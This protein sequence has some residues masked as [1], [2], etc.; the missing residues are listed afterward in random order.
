MKFP[1]VSVTPPVLSNGQYSIGG[2]LLGSG[3]TWAVQ[4]ADGL[5]L[6]KVRSQDT[7]RP[8][9][10]GEFVGLDYLSGRDITLTLHSQLG[11]DAAMRAAFT[12]L[13]AQMIPPNDG[14]DESWLWFQR[15]GAPLYVVGVRS[16][17][18]RLKSEMKLSSIKI[19]QPVILMHATSAYV[20]GPSQAQTVQVPGVAAGFRF[21]LSFNLS[22]GGGG[23]VGIINATN[24]GLKPARGVYTFTGPILDPTITNTS[25]S[26]NPSMTYNGPMAAGDRV[27]ID[28]DT[29]AP[30]AIYYTAGS[31]VGVSVLQQFSGTPFWLQVG[32]NQLAF[33][34]Q[35][36][37]PTAGTCEVLFAPPTPIAL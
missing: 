25:L 36:S 8:L 23:S 26:G 7:P 22:F 31:N 12:A 30:S 9:D 1:D 2:V 16:R 18:Y 6:T 3:Q 37:A 4:S 21:N 33:T 5:D 17:Q 19:A 35:D 29:E 24:T 10:D 11:T 14:T 32:A 13:Q 28:T 15:A 34:S 27:V 20:Y